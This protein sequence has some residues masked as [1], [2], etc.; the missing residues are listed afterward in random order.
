[1]LQLGPLLFLLSLQ[2]TWSAAA[3]GM[4]SIRG[5]GSPQALP[6]SLA[7][8]FPVWTFLPETRSLL[9]VEDSS[10]DGWVPCTGFEKLYLPADLPPPLAL[11]ALGVCVANG[12]PRY[13]MPS[14]VLSL[15]TP[16]RS[17]RNRGANSL[18]RSRAWIDAL[19]PFSPPTESLRL[20]AFGLSVGEVRFLEDQ[21]G[22]AAWESLFV[23]DRASSVTSLRPDPPSSLSIDSGLLSLRQFLRDHLDSPLYQ[24]YHFV[25]VVLPQAPRLRVPSRRLK[26][27]LADIDAPQR[28]LEYPDSLDSE[29][30]GELDV[31]MVATSAGGTSKFLPE[32]YRDLYE[33]GNLI[34]DDGPF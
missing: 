25:D 3:Q 11:P 19:A 26:M 7:S 20:S 34:I 1:M 16:E 24:G 28:L 33:P 12:L 27:Y 13:L 29:P 21:D 9:R 15:S 14:V 22:A 30:L 10:S 23:V 6:S 4:I 18:P 32:V 2:R 17:W 31:E 8:S 5:G